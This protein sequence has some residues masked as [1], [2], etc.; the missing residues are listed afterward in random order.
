M[1][2]QKCDNYYISRTQRE[3]ERNMGIPDDRTSGYEER[4]CFSCEGS[5]KNCKQYSQWMDY[6]YVIK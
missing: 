3:A 6:A 5:N 2:E 1:E 4:G